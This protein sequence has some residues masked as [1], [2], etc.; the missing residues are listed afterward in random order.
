MRSIERKIEEERFVFV[1]LNK[2]N[3]FTKPDVR[4]V[5]LELFEFTIPLVGIIKVVITP[6]VRCLPDS[7]AAMPDDILKATIL[8]PMR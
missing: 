4:A 3:A 5:A 7:T 6:I 8:G 1:L 2:A